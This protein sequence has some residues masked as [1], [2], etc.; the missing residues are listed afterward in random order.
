MIFLSAGHSTTDSG[1]VAFG[2]READIAVE[3]RNIVSYYL[4]M[5]GIRLM[6]GWWLN[7]ECGRC[8]L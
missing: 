4:L 1:A 7:A 8:Q 6:G 2:R 3:F 5:A